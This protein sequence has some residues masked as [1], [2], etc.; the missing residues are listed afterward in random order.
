MKDKHAII[1]GVGPGLGLALVNRFVQDHFAVSM[2]ARSQDILEGFRRDL[3]Q[4]GF[5]VAPFATDA[6]HPEALIDSLRR[7]QQQYGPA[8]VLIYHAAVLQPG[9]IMEYALD[10]FGQDFRINVLGAIQAAREVAPGMQEKGRGTI[11]LTGGGL[12]Y[13]PS[14]DYASLTLGKVGILSV[15]QMLNQA[16]SPQGIQVATVTINGNIKKDT[17]FSPD[18]I[19]ETYWQVYRQYDL[20]KVEVPYS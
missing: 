16:L 14:K 20:E 18:K 8:D 13:S 4:E 3:S 17:H 15:A 12:A 7:A 10:T 6:G 19:A 1:I 9:D 2:L 5:A 11:L